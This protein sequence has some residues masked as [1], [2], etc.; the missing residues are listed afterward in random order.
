MKQL[1]IF[2]ILT[3]ILLPIALFLALMF[4]YTIYAPCQSALL[5]IRFCFGRFCYLY[6]R[7]SG[8]L[9]RELIAAAPVASLI[10]DWIRVNAFVSMF[11]HQ[12]FLPRQ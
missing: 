1:T 12:F 2:R 4:F 7:V 11:H 10:R 5:L 9:K 8:F 6:F 3:F